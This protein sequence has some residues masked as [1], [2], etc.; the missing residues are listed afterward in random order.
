[1]NGQ[2]YFGREGKKWKMNEKQRGIVFFSV[3]KIWMCD[4]LWLQ[5]TASN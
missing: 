2:G 3:G 4:Y 5:S 1:M